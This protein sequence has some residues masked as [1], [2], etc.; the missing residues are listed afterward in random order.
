MFDIGRLVDIEIAQRID[1]R[2]LVAIL[3]SKPYLVSPEYLLVKQAGLVCRENQLTAAGLLLGNLG[4]DDLDH[5]RMHASFNLVYE[6][7]LVLIEYAVNERDVFNEPYRAVR[8]ALQ[9][10]LAFIAEHVNMNR[11]HHLEEALPVLIN[12][13]RMDAGIESVLCRD[14][15]ARC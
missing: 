10:H 9:R 12:H 4:Y 15:Y 1:L 13:G 5:H 2:S 8:L 6:E 14:S 3:L 11:L 7:Y